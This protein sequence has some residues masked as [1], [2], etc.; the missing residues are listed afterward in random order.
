EK[1]VQVRPQNPTGDS[2]AG[3]YHVVMIVPV[4][5][6]VNEAEHVAHEHRHK[7]HQCFQAVAMRNLH[8][9][10]HDR[11][12]DGDDPVAERLQS[13]LAHCDPRAAL[14]GLVRMRTAST[15]SIGMAASKNSR[16][17]SSP[18]ITSLSVASRTI[19]ETS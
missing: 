19:P 8:L 4:N 7:W 15:A 14:Y 10:H 11:D 18:R 5:A 9:E 12:D 2:S 13:V 1:Q 16:P 6:D 3:V 17:E